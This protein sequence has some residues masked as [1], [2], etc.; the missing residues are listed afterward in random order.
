MTALRADPGA[1]PT[2]AAR[3]APARGGWLA[4]APALAV[5]ATLHA[6]VLIALAGREGSDV[7]RP[8]AVE[9]AWVTPFLPSAGGAP[10]SPAA[11]LAAAAAPQVMAERVAPP[12]GIAPPSPPPAPPPARAATGAPAPR[13]AVIAAPPPAP[14]QPPPDS[15]D[16]AGLPATP[17]PL[18]VAAAAPAGQPVDIAGLPSPQAPPAPPRLPPRSPTMR[19]APTPPTGVLP[20]GSAAAIAPQMPTPAAG[21]TPPQPGGSAAAIPASGGGGGAGSDSIAQPLAGNPSPAYPFAA[22]RAQR[23]GRTVLRV[24]VSPEGETREVQLAES[25][26][27]ASLD[28]A[29]LHA[30]RGWRF[31]PARRAGMPVADEILVPVQF[32]LAP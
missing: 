31:A 23:E 14:P 16:S 27:T 9:L 17:A 1:A 18:A 5:S 15:A 29:A 26:G 6:A 4:F 25:S 28:E 30:V 20:A 11:G 3:R 2:R 7:A 22:R 8:L 10:A 19:T 24:R 21:P 32:R 12:A 13:N